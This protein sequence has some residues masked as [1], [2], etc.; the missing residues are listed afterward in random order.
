MVASGRNGVADVFVDAFG[1]SGDVEEEVLFSLRCCG[2]RVQE[3][4]VTESPCHEA[5]SDLLSVHPVGSRVGRVVS[6]PVFD[7]SPEGFGVFFVL[8]GGVGADDGVD[9][10]EA[11]GFPDEFDVGSGVI[12]DL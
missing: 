4:V 3:G 9:E 6:C 8:G 5:Q 2:R 1:L 12:G 7:K 10:G 11:V